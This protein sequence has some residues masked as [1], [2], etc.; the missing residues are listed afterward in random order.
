MDRSSHYLCNKSDN[1]E[2]EVL[3]KLS[4]GDVTSRTLAANVTAKR[5]QLWP[6]CCFGH[7]RIITGEVSMQG[8][9]GFF[10]CLSQG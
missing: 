6:S 7:I 3:E 10:R 5:P 9:D 1:C 2:V 4:I 8:L